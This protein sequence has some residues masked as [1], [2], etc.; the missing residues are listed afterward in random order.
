MPQLIA[1]IAAVPDLIKLGWSIFSFI[2]QI[3]GEDPAGFV[4]RSAEVFTDLSKAKTQE[5]RVDAARKVQDL[6][7]RL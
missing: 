4:K 5:E 3:A 7:R 6:I 2:K 1:F